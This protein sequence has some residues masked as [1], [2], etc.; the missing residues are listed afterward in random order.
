MSKKIWVAV[1]NKENDKLYSYA[2]PL[3]GN[4]K[5]SW[6]IEN[7]NNIIVHL[8]DTK[9][10]AYNLVEEWNKAYKENGTYMFPTSYHNGFAVQCAQIINSERGEI[11]MFKEINYVKEIHTYKLE[12][13]N[14]YLEIKKVDDNGTEY[15]M[16]SIYREG[17]DPMFLVGEAVKQTTK[18]TNWK[19]SEETLDEFLSTMQLVLY[20]TDGYA[21]TPFEEYDRYIEAMEQSNLEMLEMGD[22]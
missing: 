20:D 17:Y 5:S 18:W 3:T 8:C 15:W 13:E 16:G 22:K 6:V 21:E 2:Q 4:L 14:W 7:P 12:E 1:V 11:K 9:K 19:E 10:E